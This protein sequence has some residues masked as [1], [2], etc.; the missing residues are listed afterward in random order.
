MS[1]ETTKCPFLYINCRFLIKMCVNLYILDYPASAQ[2]I[3]MGT[4]LSFPSPWSSP[5]SR[6]DFNATWT[7]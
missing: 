6:P 4:F 1:R 3:M 7:T 2:G 5:S